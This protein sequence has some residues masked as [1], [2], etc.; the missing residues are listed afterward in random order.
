MLK[1]RS[2]RTLP[3]SDD[4]LAKFYF[5]YFALV[6]SSHHVFSAGMSVVTPSPTQPAALGQQLCYHPLLR[7]AGSKYRVLCA[8]VF[9]SSLSL[10][11]AFFVSLGYFPFCIRGRSL[12]FQPITTSNHAGAVYWS[13]L[14]TLELHNTWNRLCLITDPPCF[15][16]YQALFSP[17]N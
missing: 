10:P 13:A 15:F 12:F 16:V 2:E 6:F 3:S 7:A 14:L 8:L 5:L 17:W 11:V 9:I 4:M 1:Y